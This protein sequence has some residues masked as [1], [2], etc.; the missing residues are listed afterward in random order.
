MRISSSSLEEELT[1]GHTS[2]ELNKQGAVPLSVQVRERVLPMVEVDAG[3]GLPP[4]PIFTA[5]IIEQVVERYGEEHGT[6]EC[7]CAHIYGV[8]VFR[9]ARGEAFR[10]AEP[11]E[12]RTIGNAA[13]GQT[14][15]I[16]MQHEHQGFDSPSNLQTPG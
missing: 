7:P 12:H 8:R 16:P 9:T 10:H 3:E 6:H 13:A 15:N 11:R 2:R 1:A 14:Q 4:L 5:D